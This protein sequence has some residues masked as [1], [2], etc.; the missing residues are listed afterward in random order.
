M[1]FGVLI[2]SSL[3]LMSGQNNT[4]HIIPISRYEENR[5]VEG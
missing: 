1:T 2:G 3:R 4:S 5:H